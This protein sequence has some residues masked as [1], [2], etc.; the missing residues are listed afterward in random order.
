MCLTLEFATKYKARN[1]KPNVATDD[2]KVY[3]SLH[4][5]NGIYMA[6]YRRDFKWVPGQHYYRVDDQSEKALDRTVSGTTVE[7]NGALHCC[8][9]RELANYKEGNRVVVMIIP[10]G[11]NYF[12]DSLGNI[13]TD[14]LIFP[15][16]KKKQNV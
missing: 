14:N 5:E 10:K 2:F 12:E 7:V 4:V 6:P 16:R 13:A 8:R 3:K 9:T 11:A 15:E 1:A